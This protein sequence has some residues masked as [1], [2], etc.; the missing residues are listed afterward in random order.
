MR[1]TGLARLIRKKI[2]SNVVVKTPK[3]SRV[4]YA[5]EPDFGL[6]QV[7]CKPHLRTRLMVGWFV[8]TTTIGNKLLPLR[9]RPERKIEN[10]TNVSPMVQYCFID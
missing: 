9:M 10:G 1:W 3:G 5:Y 6:F 2:V 4:K 7:G 8:W